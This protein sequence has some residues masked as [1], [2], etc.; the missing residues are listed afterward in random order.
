[1]AETVE[2]F[3]LIY[4]SDE[5]IKGWVK[6]TA[7]LKRKMEAHAIDTGTQFVSWQV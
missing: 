2:G 1:M 7:D 4:K 6:N 3:N 5:V